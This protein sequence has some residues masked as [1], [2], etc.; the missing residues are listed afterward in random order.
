[1]QAKPN[2]RRPQLELFHPSI[3]IPRWIAIPSEVKRKTIR[4][5]ARLMRQHWASQRGL[6]NREVGGE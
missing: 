6:E 1:M 5:L 2:S 3:Q 4:F